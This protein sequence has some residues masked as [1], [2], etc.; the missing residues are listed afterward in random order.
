MKFYRSLFAVFI[1]LTLFLSCVCFTE[2]KAEVCAAEASKSGEDFP[3]K[4]QL[5]WGTDKDI[6]GTSVENKFKE[7]DPTVKERLGEFLKWKYYYEISCK[8]INLVDDKE[9]KVRMSKKC[10]IEIQKIEGQTVEV[11]LYGEDKMV[12]KKR[13]KI[14]AKKPQSVAGKTEENS[15]FWCVLISVDDDPKGE[16]DAEKKAEKTDKK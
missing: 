10:E 6:K 14:T 12:V 7:V 11:K 2:L 8:R 9:Q 1:S 5:I 15:D 16:K 4:L 13:A 3:L